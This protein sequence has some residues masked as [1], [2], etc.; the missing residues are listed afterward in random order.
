MLNLPEMEEA[1]VKSASSALVSVRIWITAMI[2]YHNTLKEVNPLR[3]IAKSKGEEL[4]AVMAVVAQKRAQVKAIN[5]KL[6]ALNAD[7]QRLEDKKKELTDEMEDC[8][9]KLIRAD[10]MISGL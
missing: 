8:A 5:D 3:A 9:K 10:A 7:E 6:A 2:K 1:K 4:A